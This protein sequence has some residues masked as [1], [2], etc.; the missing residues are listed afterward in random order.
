MCLVLV[1]FAGGVWR[2]A[3]GFRIK[4]PVVRREITV[5]GQ[6]GPNTML[7]SGWKDAPPAVSSS[8]ATMNPQAVR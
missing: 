1:L 5:P 7:A 2:A 3:E 8:R 4:H 6:N